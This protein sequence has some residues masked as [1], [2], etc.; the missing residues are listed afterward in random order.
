MST[1]SQ[2]R[3]KMTPQERRSVVVALFRERHQ[4]W[5]DG[6]GES[7][8]RHSEIAALLD[9]TAETHGPVYYDATSDA[10]KALIHEGI[11][12][13]TRPAR[14]GHEGGYEFLESGAH[15][16]RND[17]KFQLSLRRVN[18]EFD[19]WRSLFR[20]VDKA[21]VDA[22]ALELE[23]SRF[24]KAFP[25]SDTAPAAERKRF[26]QATEELARAQREADT[27]MSSPVERL[28]R[29]TFDK[30]LPTII[31]SVFDQLKILEET[32]IGEHA[33]RRRDEE[34]KAL[35]EDQKAQLRAVRAQ[36]TKTSSG[37]KEKLKKREGKIATMQET[38]HDLKVQLEN[39]QGASP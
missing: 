26:L 8:V 19:W 25:K 34:L 17:H 28:C 38:I 10:V 24:R 7:E 3:G 20:R 6:L 30:D 27:E 35:K 22:P 11:A 39:R 16:R 14:V 33:V 5:H 29:R 2:V 36:A 9:V 21:R 31:D 23:I 1:H 4:Q 13:E 18:T 37:L 12:I 32:D 15:R